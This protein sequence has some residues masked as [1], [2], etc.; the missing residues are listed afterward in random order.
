[1]SEP[2]RT[3]AR[4]VDVVE[5]LVLAG[6][7]V[8]IIALFA[9]EP[10]PAPTLPGGDVAGAAVF[11]ANCA[12]CHGADGGGGVGPQLSDGAVVEAY[13]DVA[14]EIAVITEGRAGMPA[15]G[16]ALS[17]AEIDAV[18]RYTRESL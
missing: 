12:A 16:D 18:A 11:E 2:R 1:V 17:P 7:V 6:A 4:V 5:Y 8:T 15:F 10:E 3:F 14:D 13:P 9:N